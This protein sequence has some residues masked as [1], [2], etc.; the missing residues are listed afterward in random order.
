MKPL[1]ASSGD[2]N[3][4]R[5][6]D[7]AEMLLASGEPAQAAELLLGALELVADKHTKAQF[8]PALKLSERIAAAAYQNRLIFRAFGDNILGFAPAL[9]YTE[10]DFDLMFERLEKTLNDVLAQAEVRAALKGTTTA[11]HQVKTTAAAC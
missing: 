4:D 10:S 11:N 6:A 5:R 8:D 2:L 3:A 7:F 9:S 1:Q